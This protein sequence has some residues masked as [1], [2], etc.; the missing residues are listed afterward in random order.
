MKCRERLRVEEEDYLRKKEALLE[1]QKK[2]NSNW[3]DLEQNKRFIMAESKRRQILVKECAL[4]SQKRSRINE[5]MLR[6]KQD[7]L[8][9]LESEKRKG[10]Q[11]HQMVNSALIRRVEDEAVLE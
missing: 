3:S 6:L 2:G 7:E 5:L 9:A 10:E 1:A 11:I 8:N 4:N